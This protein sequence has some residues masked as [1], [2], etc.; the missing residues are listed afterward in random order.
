MEKDKQIVVA[1][2]LSKKQMKK[3]KR[4]ETEQLGR[5]FSAPDG[6][7]R[8]TINLPEELHKR[9][10]SVALASETTATKIIEDLLE[11]VL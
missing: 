4:D 11:A 7:K 9:L 10:K 6:Y 8:L 5:S 1:L 3:M 2:L